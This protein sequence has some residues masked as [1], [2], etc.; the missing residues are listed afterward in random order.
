MASPVDCCQRLP[1]STSL[2][3]SL[4]LTMLSYSKCSL[5]PLSSARNTAPVP[6]VL[7]QVTSIGPSGI[8]S[9]TEPCCMRSSAMYALATLPF[10]TPITRSASR[11][12]VAFDAGTNTGSCTATYG[13]RGGAAAAAPPCPATGLAQRPAAA[14][15]IA[16]A[17]QC[18]RMTSGLAV[19]P[20]RDHHEDQHARPRRVGGSEGRVQRAGLFEE[21]LPHA[22]NPLRLA[23]DAKAHPAFED[24]PKDGAAVPVLPRPRRARAEFDQ[25]QVERV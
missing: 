21:G 4:A 22:E 20:L 25:P 13:I 7:H 2:C 6:H 19:G 9:S 23:V 12:N 5:R 24:N 1:L 15:M 16:T 8:S 17:T 14:A 11:A 10:A 18:A 3:T